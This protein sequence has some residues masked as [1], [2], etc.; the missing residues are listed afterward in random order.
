MGAFKGI[1]VNSDGRARV[2]WK[3]LL[4][5]TVFFIAANVLMI[6]PM[7]FYALRFLGKGPENAAGIGDLVWELTYG[8]AEDPV[9]G[10]L[11]GLISASCMTGAIWLVLKLLDKKRFSDIGLVF[12]K[13]SVNNLVYGLVFGALSMAAVFGV[14]AATGDITVQNGLSEPNINVSLLTGLGLFIL[15]GF[16]EELFTRGYCMYSLADSKKRWFAPVVSSVIFSLMHAMNA[17]LSA[18]GLFNIFFIGLLFAYMTVKT[19]DLWMAI[20]YHITWNYFQ[21]NIFGFPVSGRAP[22]GIYNLEVSGRSLLNGGGFG[23][24]GGLVVTLVI[25][26][27]FAVI[28][29]MARPKLNQVSY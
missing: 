11:A 23:P 26:V 28:H 29:R 21:G 5:F 4:V 2:G 22:D 14:L 8:L 10:L 17:N 27:G 3:I 20:G 25:L 1:F 6:V 19:G 9:F 15:V 12:T 18:L 16:N 13:T 24:E 7:I